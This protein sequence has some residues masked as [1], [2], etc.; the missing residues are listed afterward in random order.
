MSN[1]MTKS[2]TTILHYAVPP[3]IG[4]V[5]GVIQA[6]CQVFRQLDL[7]VAVVA[8]RGDVSAL[9]D[10]TQLHLIPEVDTQH[11]EVLQIS[12]A[13]EQGQVPEKPFQQW[14]GFSRPSGQ[15]FGRN[16]GSVDHR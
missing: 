12:A 11:P 5:E 13:L 6:H 15:I 9:A 4:G 14:E 8:G 7:P 10:G 2:N 1:Q 3:V 16:M